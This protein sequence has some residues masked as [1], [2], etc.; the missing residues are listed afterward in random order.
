MYLRG[1]ALVLV[2]WSASVMVASALPTAPALRP[3]SLPILV[4]VNSWP[5]RSASQAWRRARSSPGRSRWLLLSLLVGS[6]SSAV[7]ASGCWRRA[8]RTASTLVALAPVVAMC[9]SLRLGWFRRPRTYLD[10]R[11]DLKAESRG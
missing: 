7:V 2:T 10:C 9:G 5:G 4:G 3:S 11:Q 1:L 6:A 8:S